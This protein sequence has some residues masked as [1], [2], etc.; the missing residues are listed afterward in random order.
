[1]IK[2]CLVCGRE[3]SSP[4]SAGKVTCSRECKCKR[5]S[6]LL[7]GHKVS[8][9]AKTKISAAAKERG[10][11]ENLKKGTPAAMV[12][13]KAGRFETNSSA[14]DWTIM[15]PSGDVYNIVNLKNWIR[16]HM[17]LFDD[18]YTEEDVNRISAGFRVAKNNME[19]GRN[20]VTYK[21]WSI[22]YCGTKNIEKVRQKENEDKL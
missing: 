4:P 22:L 17:D 11:T 18:C 10:Q 12:S 19:K 2:N 1:M 16:E 21:G 7:R 3:F 13:P 5:R 9:D 15:S 14:K 20:T 6:Q 8:A